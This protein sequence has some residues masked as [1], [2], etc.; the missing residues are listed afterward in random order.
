MNS[1]SETDSVVKTKDGQVIVI[2]GLM[3]ENA[4]DNRGSVPGIG[5]IPA[6]G[7][8]FTKGG[9]HSVKRELVILLKPTVVKGDDAWS[10]D[11]S[12][13]QGRMETLNAKMPDRPKY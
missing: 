8:L 9:Q 5:E 7:A 1:I 12:A 13:T 11:I 3:T 4:T 6:V 2:G 10:N